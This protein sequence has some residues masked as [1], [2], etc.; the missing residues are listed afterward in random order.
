[1]LEM[2]VEANVDPTSYFLLAVCLTAENQLDR[3]L[4]VWDEAIKRQPSSIA[5]SYNKGLT[6]IL[7]DQW[8]AALSQLERAALL[9]PAGTCSACF[10]H[11][12]RA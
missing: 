7:K 5:V 2:V 8:D 1:M 6:Y 4:Q 12:H 11:A 3:A 10:L 9:D